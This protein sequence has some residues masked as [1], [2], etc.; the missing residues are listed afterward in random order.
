[1]SIQIIVA[2]AG[3][4]PITTTFSAPSD[5][6]AHLEVNGSIWSQSTNV[7]LGI[8]IE[9]DGNV[10][11]KAQIFSNGNATHRAVIPAFIKVQFKQGQHTLKLSADSNTIS[12]FNDRYSVVLH[13]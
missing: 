10:I 2:Q 7:L 8:V 9:L 4:L 1:M 12:D 3:P 11:G 5:A 13:Y 6:P